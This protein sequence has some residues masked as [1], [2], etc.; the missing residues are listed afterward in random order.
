M[1]GGQ[2]AECMI[3]FKLLFPLSEMH[4]PLQALLQMVCDESHHILALSE[5]RGPPSALSKG[6]PS[7][8]LE[9]FPREGPGLLEA[10]P[11]LRRHPSPTL[12]KGEKVWWHSA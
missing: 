10:I 1:S 3:S 4:V 6:E 5:Y 12:L 11:A 9:R 8:S 7:A 2:G